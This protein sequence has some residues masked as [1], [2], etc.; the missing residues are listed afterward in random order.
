MSN[1]NKGRE[2]VNLLSDDEG[3]KVTRTSNQNQTE[4]KSMKKATLLPHRKRPSFKHFFE[5]GEN[6]ASNTNKRRKRSQIEYDASST[7]KSRKR[8]L[9]LIK[10]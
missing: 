9:I 7:N 1:L 3:E 2:I 8:S 10:E 4:S 6:D 5:E